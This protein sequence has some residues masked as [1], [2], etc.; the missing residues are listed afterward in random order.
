MN[1]PRPRLAFFLLVAALPGCATT[2]RVAPA[3][4]LIPP[5]DLVDLDA[6]PGAYRT[7]DPERAI[8]FLRGGHREPARPGAPRKNVLALSGGGMYGAYTAGVLKGWTASGKRPTFDV[9][10]GISTGSLIAP[11]AF[12]GPEYDDFLEAR[13]TTV[14]SKD[15]YRMRTWVTLPWSDSIADSAPL[16]R[17]IAQEIDEPLLEK[18]AAAHA[19]GR[20]LYVGTTGLDSKRLVVWDM[21][22]IASSKRPGRV[23]LFRDVVLASCSVPGVLPPVA[24]DVTVDGRRSTELHADGGV[25]ASIFADFS[26]LRAARP[27]GTSPSD[28][29]AEGANVYAIVAGKI[30][31]DPGRVQQALFSVADQSLATVLQ[32]RSDGDLMRLFLMATLS[33]GKFQLAAVPQDMR[34]GANALDFDPVLMRQLFEAGHDF[35]FSGRP[36][37]NTPP[38]LEPDE[39]RLPRSGVFFA[40]S[41]T[42]STLDRM[43]IQAANR[44]ADAPKQ[45]PATQTGPRASVLKAYS[46]AS[47]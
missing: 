2:Q 10:T 1:D 38:G 33:G 23:E 43:A 27:A 25:T 5:G 11:F 44:P 18:I 8:E 15:I 39:Q 16:R 14:R 4:A 7:I 12:L 41:P 19:K 46:E 47:P 20:R 45:T 3:T 22:A 36:W 9:V 40:T 17:L 26:M 34:V 29:L 21:G 42:T 31:P 6:A 35:A 37:R 28:H 32:A 30:Y 13:Y 24:I